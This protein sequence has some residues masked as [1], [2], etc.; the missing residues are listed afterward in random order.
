MNIII[1]NILV[2]V[3]IV[4]ALW[5]LYDKFVKPLAKKHKSCGN[6]DCGC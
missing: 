1:Q 5:I 3:A 6:D 4:L 2:G